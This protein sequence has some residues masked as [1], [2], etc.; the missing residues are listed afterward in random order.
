LDGDV[1]GVAG[2]TRLNPLVPTIFHEPW[3]L[4]AATGGD[5]DEVT[6]QSGGRVTGRMPY[7]RHRMPAG[8]ALIAMPELTHVLGPAI[9]AGRGSLPNRALKQDA[10]LRELLAGL[11]ASTG[12]Y[13]KL[14]RG[15]TDTLIFQDQ[16]YRTAVQFS[17]E[18]APAQAAMIWGAMRDKTRNAVRQAAARWTVEDMADPVRFAALYRTNLARRGLVNHYHRIVPLAEAA[19]RHGQGRILAAHD[20]AGSV[21]AA[22]FYVW[23]AMTAYYLMTTRSAEATRRRA[24]WCSISMAWPRRAAGFSTPA[25]AAGLRRAISYPATRWRTVSL[26][27]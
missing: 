24:A 6:V 13:L 26:A 5:Y 8:Q 20:G 3:W 21:A 27:A 22:I 7:V 16:A 25:S 14:H 10:I 4:S 2:T 15:V 9:D 11:P 18:I 1:I 12:L 17:Y 19:L 23:D